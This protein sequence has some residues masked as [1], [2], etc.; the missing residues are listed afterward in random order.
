MGINKLSL[1]QCQNAVYLCAYQYLI[2]KIC[3]HVQT[4]RA[5]LNL[6]HENKETLLLFLTTLMCSPP[7]R[8]IVFPWDSAVSQMYFSYTTAPSP[9]NCT[10]GGTLIHSLT[11][12]SLYT[13]LE[14]NFCHKEP[15]PKTGL[16]LT[17]FN[18]KISPVRAMWVV[19]LVVVVLMEIPLTYP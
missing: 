4:V 19:D 7:Q 12:S 2:K 16:E 18:A 1:L 14:T 8:K 6:Q 13:D 11:A 15:D 3:V 10:T 17:T 9:S 5:R